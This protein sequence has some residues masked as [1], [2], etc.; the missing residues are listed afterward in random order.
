M[1]LDKQVTIYPYNRI[2]EVNIKIHM[3]YRIQNRFIVCYVKFYVLT[4]IC[5]EVQQNVHQNVIEWSQVG[6]FKGT[7]K[8][9]YF[10]VLPKCLHKP[11]LFFEDI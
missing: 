11:L 2:L 3:E 1:D 10:S 9:L 8:H 7:F 5:T 4:N 6:G